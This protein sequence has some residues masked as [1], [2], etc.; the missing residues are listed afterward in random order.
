MYGGEAKFLGYYFCDADDQIYTDFINGH[1]SK[2]TLF[3]PENML[4]YKKTHCN[5]VSRLA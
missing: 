3:S 5:Q 4:F 1:A 2:K